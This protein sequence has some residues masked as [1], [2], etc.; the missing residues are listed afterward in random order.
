MPLKQQKATVED[1]LFIISSPQTETEGI[2]K[3]KMR[4]FFIV[5]KRVSYFFIW[6][7]NQ[8]RAASF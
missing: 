2:F 6:A 4:R 3:T 1:C 8:L 7:I 5:L